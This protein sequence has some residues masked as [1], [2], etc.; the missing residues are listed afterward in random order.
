MS[1]LNGT[2][3]S[4]SISGSSHSAETNIKRP[5]EKLDTLNLYYGSDDAVHT[6]RIPEVKNSSG[7]LDGLKELPESTG[8]A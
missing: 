3:Y 2:F 1:N 4:N 8:K 6:R 7:C 5:G